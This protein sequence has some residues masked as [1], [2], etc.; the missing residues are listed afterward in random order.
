ML[1]TWGERIWNLADGFS[2]A[3]IGFA[4][5]GLWTLWAN[6]EHGFSV[7]ARAA[8]LHGSI[9]FVVTY[10][11]TR[12]MRALYAL[13]GPRWWRFL[14]CV[15]G[16]LISLYTLIVAAHWLNG[17]PEILLTLA[18]GIPITVVFCVSFSWGLSQYGVA[19]PTPTLR[20][21]P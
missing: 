17:T 9:S 5:Y 6:H 19:Q 7:A 16:T 15:L 1:S 20:T 18:P 2:G 11:G 8:V 13:P 21:N 3:C 12:L 4:F 10:S 14:R